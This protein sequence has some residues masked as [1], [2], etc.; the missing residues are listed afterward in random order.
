MNNLSFI[1][2]E[3]Y[4]NKTFNFNCNLANNW[5]SF[6]ECS[7]TFPAGFEKHNDF[8]SSFTVYTITSELIISISTGRM[9]CDDIINYVVRPG[10]ADILCALFV[11]LLV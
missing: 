6:N 8:S 2:V 5:Q 9:G 4:E 3:I 1:F 7:Q 10:S 11:N